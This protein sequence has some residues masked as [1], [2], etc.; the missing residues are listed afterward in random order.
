MGYN[1]VHSLT[2]YKLIDKGFEPVI[3]GNFHFKNQI[4]IFNNAEI[5]VGLH[6]SGFAN[7][8]FCKPGTRVIELKSKTAG[9]VIEHLALTNQLIYKS[10]SCE[11]TKFKGS[12]QF[13]H[14]E[15]S[16]NLLEEIINSFIK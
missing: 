1:D 16:I 15:V 8:S 10:I 13:G 12:H 9:K 6:G 7:L 11:A 14:I 3:L 2:P 5:I 4:K